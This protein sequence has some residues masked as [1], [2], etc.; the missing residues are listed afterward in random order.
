[1]SPEAEA[2]HGISLNDLGECATFSDLC[3]TV[4]PYFQRADVLVGYN[5][6]FD[7]NMVVEEFDRCGITL[8]VKDKLIVDPLRLWYQTEKRDLQS[9]HK[10]F[11]GRALV[12]A[13][14][15]AA[16]VRAADDVLVGMT[17]EWGL[18]EK[19]WEELADLCEP[20]R[21]TF[22]GTTNH[23]LHDD[24]AVVIGFGKHKGELASNNKSYL[25]WMLKSS[26]SSSV[27]NTARK[28]LKGEL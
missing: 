25:Q 12:G 2:V 21:H 27:K 16:D 18:R 28:I 10:R 14:A 7:I 9:A 4:L 1:M 17:E 13:H 8:D 3:P 22:V 20:D 11:T 24:G 19:S 26:F 15:A 23:F 5:V 6:L